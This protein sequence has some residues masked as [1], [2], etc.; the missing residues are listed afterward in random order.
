MASGDGGWRSK[1]RGRRIAVAA[2]D[3]P[4]GR[5]GKDGAGRGRTG[6]AGAAGYKGA[7]EVCGGNSNCGL[8]GRRGWG[9]LGCTGV[10][11]DGRG[12]N[13]EGGWTLTAGPPGEGR[14]HVPVAAGRAAHRQDVDCVRVGQRMS[15]QRGGPAVRP[16]ADRGIFISDMSV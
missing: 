12:T 3:G 14:G 11:W 15:K 4:G 1:G 10:D 9:G 2:A 6:R 5:T 8:V 13:G 7:A 16:G